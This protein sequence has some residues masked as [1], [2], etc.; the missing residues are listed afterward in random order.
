M[1]A[2]LKGRIHRLIEGFRERFL[3]GHGSELAPA[4]SRIGV[5]NICGASTTTTFINGKN[6]TRTRV[7]SSSGSGLFKNS[8]ICYLMR[9]L[10]THASK[11]TP[12][13]AADR[14]RPVQNPAATSININIKKDRARN[15]TD[16]G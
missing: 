10:S 12:R 16:G 8:T 6:L 13:V 1:Q 15:I 9:F 11:V 5:A 14:Q 3:R 2:P 7:C 4:A